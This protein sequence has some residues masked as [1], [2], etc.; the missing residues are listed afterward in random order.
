[1]R[2]NYSFIF[3]IFSD[4]RT[5]NGTENEVVT[6]GKEKVPTPEEPPTKGDVQE[7][8][9]G[10]AATTGLPTGE[11]GTPPV[12]KIK[13]VTGSEIARKVVSAVRDYSDMTK[14]KIKACLLARDSELFT[15][16]NEFCDQEAKLKRLQVSLM[17]KKKELASVKVTL[18][19]ETDKSNKLMNALTDS[20][21]LSKQYRSASISEAEP[22]AT[23]GG[24]GAKSDGAGTSPNKD[25]EEHSLPNKDTEKQVPDADDTKNN[26]DGMSFQDHPDF[27]AAVKKVNL[28]T[29]NM[30]EEADSMIPVAELSPEIVETQFKYPV[31]SHLMGFIIGKN[32][33]SLRRI[34]HQTYTEIEQTSWVIGEGNN[35]ER[36]M[37][38][39]ILGSY[40]AILEAIKC[41]IDVVRRTSNHLAVKV[42][43]GYLKVDSKP[44]PKQPQ[45]GKKGKGKTTSHPPKARSK[46]NDGNKVKICEHFLKAR[47]RDGVKCSMAHSMGKK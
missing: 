47:C 39:E 9:N 38:F 27:L 25:A 3:S 26:Q 33:K 2:P 1:M 36:Y 16:A 42:M 21:S 14:D 10:N 4:H 22:P 32:K 28:E 44:Q 40:D 8:T 17:S 31:P 23:P 6:E 5:M 30:V 37:G 13:K 24:S 46:P 18:K 45:K 43:N 35:A 7:D 34:Q 20:V 29:L 11:P 41:M 19:A 12:L 15:L